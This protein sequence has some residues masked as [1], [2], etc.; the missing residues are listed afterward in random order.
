MG[1][2]MVPPSDRLYRIN[3]PPFF[4]SQHNCPELSRRRARRDQGMCASCGAVTNGYAQ[5]ARTWLWLAGRACRDHATFSC[6]EQD[7]KLLQRV[8]RP[9]RARAHGDAVPSRNT[10]RARTRHGWLAAPAVTMRR[11]L[12]LSTDNKLF[13][14]VRRGQGMCAYCGAHKAHSLSKT[15]CSGGFAGADARRF[16]CQTR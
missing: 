13:R 16:D 2:K 10:Q 8:C 6:P 5:R 15:N 3:Y 11:S 14:R 9:R 7:N 4:T 1:Q 12:V